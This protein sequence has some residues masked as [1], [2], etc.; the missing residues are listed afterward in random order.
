MAVERDVSL[1]PMVDLIRQLP[2]CE[3]T[4]TGEIDYDTSDPELI[5]PMG[6]SA[7]R[8]MAMVH[9]GIVAIGVLLAHA[10]PEIEVGSLPVDIVADLGNLLAELA[11]L[12]AQCDLIA[13]HCRRATAD[14]C[15]ESETSNV[16]A[17]E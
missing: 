5:Q 3:V 17:D 12:A 7:A 11:C 13:T 10:T 16:A 8:V 9:R 2:C 4:V 14:Y 15:P 6:E 1:H